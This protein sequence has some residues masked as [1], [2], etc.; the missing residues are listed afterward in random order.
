MNRIDKSN[1]YILPVGGHHNAAPSIRNFYTKM[2]NVDMK[3]VPTLSSP[4]FIQVFRTS[5]SRSRAVSPAPVSRW[6]VSLAAS[7]TGTGALR[8]AEP[9]RQAAGQ[10][11]RQAG[12]KMSLIIRR[13]RAAHCR[14]SP[15]PPTTGHMDTGDAEH[16]THRHSFVRVY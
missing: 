6:R 14:W 5:T 7:Q 10:A 4:C 11:D 8:Q 1:I 15:S 9:G 2:Y 12:T 13:R 3:Y 16:C